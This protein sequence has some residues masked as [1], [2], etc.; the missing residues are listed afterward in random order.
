M[1]ILA[2]LNGPNLNLLGV[3]DPLRYGA[4]SLSS[5]TEQLTTTA[6]ARGVTLEHYQS[7][8]EGALIDTI[9]EGRSRWAGLII[10]PGGYTHTSIALRD[11]LEI[12]TVP[13]IE[14]HLS[15]IHAREPFRHHSYISPLAR[16]VIVGLGARGYRLALD[17]LLGMLEEQGSQV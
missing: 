2:L 13:I 17:A 9:Q 16:G 7:N 5:I 3:R 14:V 15:N 11:A 8:S 12:L 4:T 1:A 6:S 10:N